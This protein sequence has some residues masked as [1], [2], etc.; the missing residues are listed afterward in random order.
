MRYVIVWKGEEV[1]EF[2][3][4]QEAIKMLIEYNMAYKGGCSI[5]VKYKKM[6][7]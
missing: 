2:E 1:D 5:R 4:R 7:I 6:E 3:T